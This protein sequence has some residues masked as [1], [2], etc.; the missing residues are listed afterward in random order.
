MALVNDSLNFLNR[1]ISKLKAKASR[2]DKENRENSAEE[3]INDEE[4]SKNNNNSILVQ[5]PSSTVDYSNIA[6]KEPTSE[7]PNVQDIYSY[8]DVKCETL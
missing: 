2:T 7:S 5:I 1:N 4:D 3:D 8:P 6:I